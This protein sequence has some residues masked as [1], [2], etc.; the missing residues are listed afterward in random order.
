MFQDLALTTQ[1]VSHLSSNPSFTMRSK[2]SVGKSEAEE[3]PGPGSY[4]HKAG[5][6]NVRKS[7]HRKIK[8]FG[9]GQ[10]ERVGFGS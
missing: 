6:E 5:F 2:G 1:A 4:N 8:S 3:N 9:F 7:H 10:A